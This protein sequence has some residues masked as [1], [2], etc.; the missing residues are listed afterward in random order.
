MIMEVVDKYEYPY[1]P[2]MTYFII[3]FGFY[4]AHENHRYY[5]EN[6]YLDV[7]F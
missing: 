7:I 1:E 4:I 6:F 3:I 5:N 2:Q